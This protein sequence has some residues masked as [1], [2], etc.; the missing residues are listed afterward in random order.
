MY[1]I[2]AN[3]WGIL[4]VNATIYGI[5]G[6]YGYEYDSDHICETPS[7]TMNKTWELI[8]F[9][10]LPEGAVNGATGSLRIPMFVSLSSVV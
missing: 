7:Y 5:H 9:V 8:F 3:I 10:V 1:G 6:P 2:Y 4:M